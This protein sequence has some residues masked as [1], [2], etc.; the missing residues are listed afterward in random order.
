MGLS[1]DMTFPDPPTGACWLAALLLAPSATSPGMQSAQGCAGEALGVLQGG[2]QPG[3]ERLQL[4]QLSE[5]L[6]PSRAQA[7]AQRS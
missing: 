1:S 2:N 7:H 4:L 6:R 5:Y 3:I